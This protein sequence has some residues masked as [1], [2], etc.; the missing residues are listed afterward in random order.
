MG[1][2][3]TSLYQRRLTGKIYR[4]VRHEYAAESLAKATPRAETHRIDGIGFNGAVIRPPFP[5][6][7]S[8]STEPAASPPAP[9][10]ILRRWP[11]AC[12]PEEA[13]EI[14]GTVYPAADD[15]DP[16]DLL[17]WID[18][19]QVRIGAARSL[20]NNVMAAAVGTVF[21]ASAGLVTFWVTDTP[22]IAVI[23]ALAAFVLIIGLSWL[24]LHDAQ[25]HALEQRWML[26]RR[27]ARQLGLSL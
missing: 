24:L 18:F 20:V 6:P 21:A 3:P 15:L 16:E 11:T 4:E 27:R 19:T 12:K 22:W 8:D 2:Q 23:A 7:T 14:S 26:Y 25:H 17:W 9:L 5:E 10:E 13:C 1:T